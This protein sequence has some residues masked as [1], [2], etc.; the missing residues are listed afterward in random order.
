[1]SE[2]S[3]DQIHPA[4]PLRQQQA[5]RD[6]DSPKS[7]ELVN[8]IQTM[9]AIGAGFV[10]LGGIA[11]WILNWTTETWKQSSQSIAFDQNQV[12]EQ[13]QTASFSLAA[14]L[15][16]ILCLMFAAGVLAHWSQT[17]VQ[18][19]PGKAAPDVKR[20][21]PQRWWQQLFSFH[22]LSSPFLGI[23]KVFVALVATGT[24][25]WVQRVTL[26]SLGALPVEQIG[27]QVYWIVL[28]V[29][30]HVALVLLVLSILDVAVQR[31]SFEKRIRMT[32]QQMRDETRSQNG[33]PMITSQRRRIHRSYGQH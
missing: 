5:R 4:S 16:P 33:D 3:G 19:F 25:C 29:S 1:M 8:A 7:L 2:F 14:I 11:G 13:L 30:F 26:F 17:G 12:T 31:W 28:T 24:S 9:F 27:P 18:F 20:L 10:L 15:A 22:S 6:G 32:D 23:P 21:G